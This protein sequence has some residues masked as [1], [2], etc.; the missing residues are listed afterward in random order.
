MNINALAGKALILFILMSALAVCGAPDPTP[1]PTA[2][3]NLEAR[4]AAA[5][6]FALD[7]NWLEQVQYISPRARE[8][9]EAPNYAARISV[10]AKLVI[11]MEG[12]TENPT[13]QFIIR[14]VTVEGADGTVSIG[15]LLDGQPAVL[16]DK[17]IR[18]WVLLDGQWWEEHEDWQ[19]GCV[20]WKLFEQR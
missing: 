17:G 10:F 1:T 6:S 9:C 2:S 8:V 16:E 7:Q 13:I 18:R 19:D 12:I 11:G 4:A 15:Y 5:Y 14:D 3:Q 20:G